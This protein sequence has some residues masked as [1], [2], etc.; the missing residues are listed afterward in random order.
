MLELMKGT[1]QER[2][3]RCL[4]YSDPKCGKTRLATSLPERF[5]NLIYIAADEGSENLAPVLSSYRGRLTVVRAGMG[6]GKKDLV[7]D[8]FEAA[9]HNWK[10]DVPGANTLIWDTMTASAR[11]MLQHIADTGQFSQEKHIVLGAPGSAA[12][13][14]IP[15]QGDYM[16]VQNM[17]ERLV[18]LLFQQAL[19][20]LV[21]CHATFDE[22]QG[23]GS[24]EGGPATAG[25]ATVRSFPGRF[26]SVIHLEKQVTQSPGQAAKSTV[27]AHTERHGIWS[28]GIRSQ[29]PVN[30]MPKV[31]LESDPINFWN[32]YDQNFLQPKEEVAGVSR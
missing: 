18:A 21:L 10:K 19:H 20:V 17:L 32:L 6:E 23:G 2:L 22:P 4:I 12:R 30:P 27:V 13:Q 14:A 28:A 1:Q 9:C 25:K 16:A 8:Y 5:G 26:D 15:M 24:V 7:G 3:E 29:H 31:V 11:Q